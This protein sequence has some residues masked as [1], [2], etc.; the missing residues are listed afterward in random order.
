MN[1][2]L[3]LGLVILAGGI[4]MYWLA[5]N[6]RL[7][8]YLFAG[9]MIGMFSYLFLLFGLDIFFGVGGNIP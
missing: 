7:G 5:A 4:G 3:L 9:F 6:T 1:T 2:E 8:S